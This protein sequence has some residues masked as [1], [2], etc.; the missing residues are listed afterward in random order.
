MI[1]SHQCLDLSDSSLCLDQ[2]RAYHVAVGEL[3]EFVV[4]VSLNSKCLQSC[5]SFS[6]K[7]VEI[8]DPFLFA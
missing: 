1:R 8:Y 3:E 2:L 4:A 6:Q 7:A 5:G